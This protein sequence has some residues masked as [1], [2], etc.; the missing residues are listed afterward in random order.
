[1][2]LPA[3]E[4][5]AGQLAPAGRFGRELAWGLS[6][7]DT[8]HLV[9][10]YHGHANR[11]IVYPLTSCVVWICFGH[12]H[13]FVLWHV[14]E[15][16]AN[17]MIILRATT[18]LAVSTGLAFTALR[19][20]RQRNRLDP[21]DKYRG[22]RPR[23]GFTRLDGMASLSLLLANESGSHVWTEE[24]EIFLSGLTAEEQTAEPSCREIQK[25]RQTVRSGDLLPISLC[26]VIYKA[27]G[28][29]QR[30]YTC[31]MSSVL[32]Y[33]IDEESFEKNMENYRLR[34]LGLTVSG[35]HRERKHVPPIQTQE[36]SHSVPV[37]A[38]KLK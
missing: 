35:I 32:R 12:R 29:P 31:V 6:K 38:I 28:D 24:I 27:A 9:C 23:I 20:W 8:R 37:M 14:A 15:G 26:E 25:I 1:M 2:Q 33:R 13:F 34:M 3:I 21:A 19:V 10:I 7:L 18:V 11:C 22:F 30:K 16:A 17:L 36:E 5:V 4:R